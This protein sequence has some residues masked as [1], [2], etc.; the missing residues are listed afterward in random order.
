MNRELNADQVAAI[1]ALINGKSRAEI[2]KELGIPEQEL[3]AW[4]DSPAFI[5][6][7]NV[8]RQQ[9]HLERYE[10]LRAMASKS[11]TI[12]EGLLESEDERVAHSAALAV[13]KMASNLPNPSGPTTVKDVVAHRRQDELMKSLMNV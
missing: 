12:L 8:A 10:Q 7:L 2:G 1:K 11:L 13:L 3:A 5:A 4:Q 6:E 9:A